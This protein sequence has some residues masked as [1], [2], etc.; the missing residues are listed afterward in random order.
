MRMRRGQTV[1]KA[2]LST[3]GKAITP[4]LK[5]VHYQRWLRLAVQLLP[6]M[7]EQLMAV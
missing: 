2:N 5:Q 6:S 7:F 4:L 1:R 3:S